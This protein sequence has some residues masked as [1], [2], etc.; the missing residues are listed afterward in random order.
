MQNQ[1]IFFII[2]L[3][4]NLVNL[5]LKINFYFLKILNCLILIYIFL[6]EK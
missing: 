1:L 4:F 3:I 5:H 6:K 2:K